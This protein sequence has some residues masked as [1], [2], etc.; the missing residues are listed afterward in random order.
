MTFSVA[1]CVYYEPIP[2]LRACLKQFPPWVDKI[3]VLVSEQPWYGLREDGAHE[4]MKFLVTHPDP[5]IEV[6]R[7]NWRTEQEQRNWGLG[8][9]ADNDWA[10]VFDVDEF[11]TPEDWEK[12]RT[13]AR[14]VD[15]TAPC[16]TAKSMLTYWKDQDHVWEPPDNHKPI[17]AANTQKAVFFDKR[18]IT[19]QA[20][21]E[22]DVT[23]HHLSWV[24][25]DEEV[26]RKISTWMHAK[27]FDTDKWYTDVWKAWTPEMQN[28]LRPYGFE[29][30]TRAVYRPLPDSIKRLFLQD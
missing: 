7:M 25:T 23:L 4:M 21:F 14:D 22:A 5:R 18:C 13:I 2:L 29:G 16:I 28:S 1:I 9:L 15:R 17:I 27:D 20:M 19:E 8:R 10:L 30:T 3:L 6:R 24:K 12:L 11:L 26:K